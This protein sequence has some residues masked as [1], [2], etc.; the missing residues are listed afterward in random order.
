MSEKKNKLHFAWLVL[1]GICLMVGL[2]KG[3][4]NNSAGLFLAPVAKDLG[5]GMGNLTLYFSVSAIV[6]MIF[7]PISGKL[8]AKYDTRYILSIAIILQ[9][10]AFALFGV[11]SSVW[12]WY[13][14]AIPLAVGGVFITVIA[15]PVLINTWFKKHNGLALGIMGAATGLI[16]AFSQ[17]I[18]GNLISNQGWR[19]SYMMVGIVAIVIA[20]PIIFLFLRKSPQ[21]KGLLPLGMSE[22]TSNEG[23]SANTSENSGISF[24]VAKKSAAFFSLITFF[25]IITSFGSFAIHMPT[26]L[27]HKGY[28]VT[29]A[30]NIMSAYMVGSLIGSLVFGIFSDKI[31]AKNTTL[32]AMVIGIISVTLLL[33]FANS[34]MII[35]IAV[36]L[37]GFVAASIG[38]LSPAITSALFGS[39]EYSQ[40][41]STVSMGLAVASI[42]ALP[43]YGYVYDLAGSYTPALYALIVL[44]IINIVCILIAFNSK[45]KMVKA[46]LWK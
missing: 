7:L 12:G 43:A 36:A 14:L 5:V 42:I 30:G 1:V 45:E 6:T 20:V 22:P 37:F 4:M 39:K 29:F 25:F 15:G 31:G 2:G 38:T 8:M 24:A 13:I 18:V 33:F 41:Y 46:G 32:F 10:G 11:M 21:E 17:P 3:A 34:A 28:D 35:T 16:G 27:M 9:G 19:Q 44:L 40:I 26:Y 23:G